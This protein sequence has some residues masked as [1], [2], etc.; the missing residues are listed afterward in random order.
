MKRVLTSIWLIAFG[1]YFIF[2]ARFDFFCGAVAVLSL[3]CFREYARI[4][5]GQG[6]GSYKIAGSILGLGVLLI[7]NLGVAEVCLLPVICLALAMRV[8][9]FKQGLANAGALLLGIFYI[10]G[11][12]RCGIALREMSPYWLFFAA[13][14]NWAGDVSA[15]YVGRA[16]GKH[17]LAPRVSPG[18]SIEGAV[19]NLVASLVFGC[20]FLPKF[21]PGVSILEAGALALVGNI[22]GQFGDLSESALKRGAGLKDSGTM[23][24]GHGGWL[25]R[26]DSSLFSMPTVYVALLAIDRFG[27]FPK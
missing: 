15:Y 27:L 11:A 2:E 13:A 21:I 10:F 6:A 22:A 19:A 25:D 26:L 9:D 18:K 4:S 14:L 12:W 7:P 20:L 23:L 5:E 17:K 16:I 3:L 1:V 24:A 8:E